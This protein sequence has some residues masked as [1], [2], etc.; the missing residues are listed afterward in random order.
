MIDARIIARLH[1]RRRRRRCRR[2][3]MPRNMISRR[4]HHRRIRANDLTV[5]D[6]TIRITKRRATA[7]LGPT[8]H[9]RSTST[10][11]SSLT[12]AHLTKIVH[13]VVAIIT[14]ADS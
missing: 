5:N 10:N 2:R 14:M 7:T 8:V 6:C 3:I 4:R 11:S 9:D 13:H 1:C 12:V